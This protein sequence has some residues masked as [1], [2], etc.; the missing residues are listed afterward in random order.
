MTHNIA[1]GGHRSPAQPH[2]TKTRQD[3]G[4]IA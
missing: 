3:E 1:A 4:A 2:K